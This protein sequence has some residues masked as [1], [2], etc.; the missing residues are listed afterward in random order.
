MLT[1]ICFDSKA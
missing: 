1:A